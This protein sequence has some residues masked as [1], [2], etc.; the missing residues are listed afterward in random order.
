MLPP[1][2]ILDDRKRAGERLQKEEDEAKNNGDNYNSAPDTAAGYVS[3]G[4]YGKAN[5]KPA[6]V[7]IDISEI[8][9]SSD[10]SSPR[11]E[12]LGNREVIAMNFRPRNGLS[13]PTSH[14]YIPKLLGTVWIDQAEKT[15]A[16]LEAQ[17]AP[18]F[19]EGANNRGPVLVY[20]Q[21]RR[22]T[23]EWFPTLIR[24]NAG[25]ISSLFNGL[26]WDVTFEFSEYK[27]FTSNAGDVIIKE[28]K[29]QKPQN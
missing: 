24:M 11:L 23:G 18:Q 1:W 5:G 15:V 3:A 19:T 2:Q 22:P 25:G 27:K 9:R 7:T 17:L 21:E 13:F 10:F 8:L 4:I 16:R 14:Q 29:E 26:N 6:W 20:E 28:I 12:R